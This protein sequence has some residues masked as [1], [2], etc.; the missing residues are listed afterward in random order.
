VTMRTLTRTG[1]STG[2]WIRKTS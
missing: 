1:A 2:V